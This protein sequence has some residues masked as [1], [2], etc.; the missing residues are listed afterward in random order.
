MKIR[1]TVSLSVLVCSV[2]AGGEVYAQLSAGGRPHS[3]VAGLPLDVPLVILDPPDIARLR[4]EDEARDDWPFRYGAVLPAALGL[5]EHGRWDEALGKLVWRLAL[6]S[7]GALSLGVVFDQYQIPAGGELYLYDPARAEVLGAFNEL[8][9]NAS[10]SLAIQPLPGDAVVI[11]YVQPSTVTATPRLHIGE[12]IHD[13]RGILPQLAA[14]SGNL[15]A[16]AGCLVDINCPIGA[17]YQDIKRSV[18]MVLAGGG[19]CSAGLLNNTAEDGTPYFLT[20]NHCGDMTNVVAVFNYELSGCGSGT[21]SQ[22]QTLSGASLLAATTLQDS[23]LYLL[24]QSPP[25]AYAPFYA[26]WQRTGSPPAPGI[27]ISHPSL[28]PKK[29][30]IDRDQPTFT[31]NFW[32]VQWETGTLQGGSS[33]SPLFDGNKRVLGPCCCVGG[34]TCNNQLANYGNL[35]RF[36][37]TRNLGP[38]LDPLGLNPAGIDGLDFY[39][40]SAT[41]YNGSG[42]NPVVFTS[43]SLPQL[44]TTWTVQVDTS[45]VPA[46]TS[47]YIQ[48]RASSSSGMFFSFG[49]LLIDLSSPVAFAS[50]APVSSGLST[51]SFALPNDPALAGAVAYAQAGILGAKPAVAT[52]G[53]KVRLN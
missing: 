41:I 14:W 30:A 43:L 44:G 39:A 51:H 40:P 21:S 5:E 23:Q 29:L 17:N 47:T 22:S 27:S 34:F 32:A 16:S 24:N 50:L 12:V 38:H 3:E 6:R 45:S 26:G 52:N 25:M 33:G 4:A 2:L 19:G 31:G 42:V 35:G 7:P 18:I 8:N 10:G 1:A 53:L 46:A 9:N 15:A 49:E 11:E 36:Y 48:G 37:T 28:L 20:A 13:Y